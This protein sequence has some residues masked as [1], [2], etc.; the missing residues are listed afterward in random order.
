MEKELWSY[1]VASLWRRNENYV[2]GLSD[3]ARVV[4]MAP[5]RQGF[6]QG[7]VSCMFDLRGFR[8]DGIFS[9]ILK[10]QNV[11]HKNVD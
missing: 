8:V 5:V 10:C 6:Y 11:L 4:H 9:N 2:N 3:L 7:L 1:V